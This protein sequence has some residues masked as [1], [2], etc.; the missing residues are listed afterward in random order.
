MRGPQKFWH[1]LQQRRLKALT[2]ARKV[3]QVIL[4]NH[5]QL[6]PAITPE[7]LCPD[8]DA[9]LPNIGSHCQRCALPLP[10]DGLCPEC[11]KTPPSFDSV[12]VA[13]EYDYPLDQLILNF[14]HRNHQATGR[15]L[16]LTLS[17]EL[18]LSPPPRA[19]ILTNVPLHWKRRISRGY[20]QAEVLARSL[21][22]HA[23]YAAQAVFIPDLLYKA[24]AT[25]SQQNLSRSHRQKNLQQ[26]IS[27]TPKYAE[28]VH[29]KCVAVV[30]DVVTTGATAEVIA[31]ILK[32]AGAE[33]VVFLALARTPKH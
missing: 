6:C 13:F 28:A 23:P 32:F 17:Q 8:C 14:K 7:L 10:S 30:D 27:I 20:N 3:H 15:K 26:S 4:P 9:D 24:F 18:Q 33:K 2:L 31:C 16:A 22:L 5:C 1:E 11:Q 21:R 29:G 12:R 25:T 19:D